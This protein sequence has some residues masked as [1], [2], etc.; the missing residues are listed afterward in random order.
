MKLTY[1]E[2]EELAQ[3]MAFHLDYTGWGDSWERKVSEDLRKQVAE[4]RDGIDEA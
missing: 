1:E 4:W 2:L 3:E